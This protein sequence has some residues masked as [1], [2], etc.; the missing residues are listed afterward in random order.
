MITFFIGVVLIEGG[1]ALL[2]MFR[3]PPCYLL[4]MKGIDVLKTGRGPALIRTLVGTV[5]IVLATTLSNMYK[6]E[7]R[8]SKL[9]SPTPVDHFM[10]RTYLLEVSLMGY[11]LFLA[12]IISHM[13]HQFQQI[14]SLKVNIETLK[15]QA[16]AVEKEYLRLN[17]EKNSPM[18]KENAVIQQEIISLKDI[19]ADLRK[20][21]E[22]LQLQSLEKDKAAKAAEANARALQKQS[23]GFLL[24]YDRLL[25]DNQNLRSQLVS[26]DRRLSHSD[27]K[28]NA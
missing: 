5:S 17:T 25:E 21:M 22:G 19:V 8:I 16:K 9:G 1:I 15:K 23:E 24:E 11:S 2:L 18:K 6:I 7:K 27:V 4:L 13:H 28:K 12:L 3:F 26:F 10:L 20:K 14:D